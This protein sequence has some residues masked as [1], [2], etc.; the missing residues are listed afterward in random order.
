MGSWSSGLSR[1]ASTSLRDLGKLWGFSEL[2]CL[3]PAVWNQRCTPGD[4]GRGWSL[5]PVPQGLRNPN[6]ESPCAP[7]SFRMTAPRPN[8]S[9]S[10]FS[11]SSHSVNEA[12]QI[13]RGSRFTESNRWKERA[14]LFSKGTE[15]FRMLDLLVLHDCRLNFYFLLSFFPQTVILWMPTP[16]LTA[17]RN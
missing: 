15:P 17:W 16:H 6:Q 14:P 11:E 10:F 13:P 4:K 2:R 12:V 7:A 9:P 8:R 1:C 3:R 5:S